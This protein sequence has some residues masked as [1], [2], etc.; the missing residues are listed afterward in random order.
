MC[1]TPDTGDS[2]T[3]GWFKLGCSSPQAKLAVWFCAMS[4]W[5]QSQ[6]AGSHTSHSVAFYWPGQ[7][8]SKLQALHCSCHEVWPGAQTST[9]ETAVRRRKGRIRWCP[10]AFLWI[11]A[12]CQVARHVAHSVWVRI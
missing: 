3:Q 4:P 1:V 5:Q 11:Q 8:G 6:V 9:L 2:T 7:H 10:R 12:G